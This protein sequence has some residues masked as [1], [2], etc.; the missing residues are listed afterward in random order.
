M[1][2]T[3]IASR[4]A[5]GAGRLGLAAI[6]ALA[7]TALAA[8]AEAG[9]GHDR[10]WRGGTHHHHYYHNRD[11]HNR[12]HYRG[13]GRHVHR[14]HYYRPPPRVVYRPAPPPRVIYAPPPRAYYYGPPQL[15]I[16]LPLR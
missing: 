1:S 4:I 2:N 11:Y 8:P 14:H 12:G 15:N 9:R 6:T 7:F 10:D 13:K 16:V 3:S 5:S